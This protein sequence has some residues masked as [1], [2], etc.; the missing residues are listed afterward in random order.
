[1]FSEF[2]YLIYLLTLLFFFFLS[3][4]NKLYLFFFNNLTNYFFKK[5]TIVEYSITEIYYKFLSRTRKFNFYNSTLHK[6]VKVTI[7]ENAFGVKLIL[8]K[9]E[10]DKVFFTTVRVLLNKSLNKIEISILNI[11][12]E[13]L[14]ILSSFTLCFTKNTH[15]HYT[16]I[17]FM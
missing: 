1:M 13:M 11:Q 10:R 15:N 6:E 12:R 8:N 3:F 16:K 2:Y 14:E 4:K 9:M 17:A 7:Y 5:Y